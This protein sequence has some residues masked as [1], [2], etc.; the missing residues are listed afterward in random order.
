MM[1]PLEPTIIA[2]VAMFAVATALMSFV[3]LKT[4]RLALPFIASLRAPAGVS[5]SITISGG[6][7]SL[8][9]VGGNQQVDGFLV[10]EEDKEADLLCCFD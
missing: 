2:T 5:E 1:V 3:A 10:T 4:F 9:A 8:M 6:F 7:S